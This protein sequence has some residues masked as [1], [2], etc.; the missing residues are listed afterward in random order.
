MP[1]AA[2]LDEYWSNILCERD[3]ITDVPE[4]RWNRDWY[5]DSDPATPDK[6]YAQ[7]GGFIPS[8]PFDPAQFGIPPASL[9]AIDT[10]QLMALALAAEALRDAGY[11]AG[12]E[13]DHSRTSV[14]L[15]VVGMT[16][17]NMRDLASRTE[18]PAW[19]WMMRQ[20]GVDGE[21]LRAVADTARTYYPAW[22]E[23]S[24]PGSLP[25]VV[26]GRIANRLDLGGLACSVDAACASSLCALSFAIGELQAGRCDLAV[27]GGVDMDN[28]PTS[29]LCF[30]K[31]HALSRSQRVRP[32]AD[33]ADGTLLA[34]GAGLL[35]LKRQEDAVRDGD[36]IYALI[37]GIG[38]TSD[39]RHRSIYAPRPEGQ[40]R[41]LEQAY[42]AADVDPA[43]IGLIEAHATG[44]EVGDIVEC[45]A[46]DAFFGQA[47]AR[48]GSVALGSVK[49]QI[50]HAKA[51]AGAA[52]L[53]KAA[54]AL[55]HRVLPATLHAGRPGA[56]L[57]RDGSPLSVNTATRPWFAPRD[58][59]PRRAGVSAFGFGGA[60]YHAVLE[61]APAHAPAASVE[62][63]WRQAGIVIAAATPE[64]LA[65]SC[66]RLGAELAGA[67][68]AEVFARLAAADA[69]PADWARIGF[70]AGNPA[71]VAERLAA[72]ETVLL[73]R[74]TDE[75][76]SLPAG[77][78]YRRRAVGGPDGLV[79]LFPGQGSQFVGMGCRLAALTDEVRSI[80]EAFDRRLT[81]GGHDP[82]SAVM[83]PPGAAPAAAADA[84]LR[85]TLYAQA[86]IGAL[87]VGL[88]RLL[89][90]AGVEPDFAGGHSFGE[91][92][93]LWAAG[94]MDE[95]TY[96][97]LVI[98]RGEALTPPADC[99]DAGTLLAVQA[100]EEQLRPLLAELPGVSLAN[101]NAPHQQVLGGSRDAVLRAETRLQAEGL[102][103]IPL[104][105]AAAFHTPLVSYAKPRWHGAL[106][107][108]R[109]SS[110]RIPVAANGAGGTHGD[111]PAAIA[112]ALA[113]HPFQ[114]VLFR[115]N[116]ETLYD[117]GGRIFLEIGPR[118]VLSRLAGTIL[119]DRPHAAIA[120]NHSSSA[121]AAVQLQEALVQLRVAG[122]PLPA[123]AVRNAPVP[124]SPTTI[125]LGAPAIGRAKRTAVLTRTPAVMPSE[126]TMPRPIPSA[127]HQ[128]AA[129]PAPVTTAPVTTAPVTPAPI[130][131][132]SAATLVGE[133]FALERAMLDAH[134]R[135]LDLQSVGVRL[136]GALASGDAAQAGID[137]NTV[138]DSFD[139]HHRDTV[140]LHE[141][142][143]KRSDEAFRTLVTGQVPSTAG[144]G[145]AVP[146]APAAPVPAVVA[147]PVIR[148]PV[149]PN[150][151]PVAAASVPVPAAAFDALDALTGIVAERTQY[152]REF[153]DPDLDLEADLGIDSIKRVEILSNLRQAVSGHHGPD[154]LSPAVVQAMARARS[155]RAIA[156]LVPAPSTPAP[157]PPAAPAAPAIAAPSAT[158]SLDVDTVLK[159]LVGIVADRTGYPE[160]ILDPALD[161][162]ADLGIDSI[163]RMDILSALRTMA[164]GHGAVV[165]APSRFI[166]ARTLGEIARLVLE[167][168]EKAAV[169]TPVAAPA[170]DEAFEPRVPTLIPLPPVVPAADP[171][172]GGVVV[173]GDDTGLAPALVR[174]LSAAGRGAVLAPILDDPARLAETL[175]EAARR[176][177]GAETL[178]AVLPA[179]PGRG[180]AGLEAVGQR[181]RLRAVLL[182]A[183]QA[184]AL[185][186]GRPAFLTVGRQDGA[187]GHG[188]RA[189]P[190]EP[191]GL[192]GLART[193][194]LEHP[195]VFAR[196]LDID[197][198]LPE[199]EA[200]TAVLA[201][202][203]DASTDD[204][205]V[206][207][208][209][210][211]RW[212]LSAVPAVPA[213]AAGHAPG[214][215]DLFLVTGGGRGITA[216]CV[217][218]L[219]RATGCRF[220][221]AGRTSI[222]G[223][224]PEWARGAAEGDLRRLCA[225][226]LPPGP[227]G[228]RPPIA[229]IE[230]AVQ[231]VLRRRSVLGT[232]DDLARQGIRARYVT[233][234]VSAPDA[235]RVALAGA[236]C[237]QVTGLIHGA[238][239][240]ADRSLDRK[241]AQDFDTVFAPKV[242]GLA[243]VLDALDPA[244]LRHIV[245]FS[246]TA[247]QYGN[248]GQ[249]DY[250]MA[251]CVL[252]GAAACL[253]HSLPQARVTA[254]AWGPWQGGMVDPGLLRHF[255][256][257]GVRSLPL[258]TGAALFAR[259][260]CGA[261]EN[262]SAVL[263]VGD[264][265]DPGG[266]A[267]APAAETGR[268]AETA[269]AEV[270][271]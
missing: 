211:G 262:R 43:T 13:R 105:V 189:V 70:V 1:Q 180:P 119:G 182:A 149:I 36:R 142:F 90:Q 97:D 32:F 131:P 17:A 113:E 143:L 220:V 162:E 224:E 235:L 89:R 249:A 3:C 94:V 251:N 242:D 166:G 187:F 259:A 196:A 7:R 64:E 99:A 106:R 179:L 62:P 79:A 258:D 137:P 98:A 96:I 255:A 20:Q 164:E 175:A 181:A 40:A 29:Y 122:L 45:E 205:V 202:L 44:T 203:A 237:G 112:A 42:R 239:A 69:P 156:A 199:D 171:R 120:V 123:T 124:T 213:T 38:A 58:G 18:I 157:Q 254:I 163:K 169:P 87:G 115:R 128:P 26:A 190:A 12:R 245:L 217:A 236:G 140:A 48:P 225:A 135:F 172:R 63:A 168:G 59:E 9:E 197:E 210:R 16:L 60:N 34:E 253:R 178:I 207:I 5:F 184:G 200:A 252:D 257:R 201:E 133:G 228:R 37:R 265:P 263:V 57:G 246:S 134:A 74:R 243:R 28:S 268:M 4:S 92:T 19:E 215:E 132:A 165:P 6:I 267:D 107:D 194:R 229:A 269:L 193:L 174:A 71:E 247:G 170:G 230:A 146:A 65:G 126:P 173:L 238:G 227:D 185:L 261:F 84:A 144:F 49:S 232:L 198:A 52:S 151:A 195:G 188:G 91:L 244:A 111:D 148:H 204:A 150:P 114:P 270:G 50:G 41:V 167:G 15:G 186:S 214:A 222:D 158:G 250:A 108:V 240:L 21:R 139:R 233:A 110:P 208:D 223:D 159:S 2:S 141:A 83:M 104:S 11:P 78:F 264:G 53:I 8:I 209:H 109:L 153:L 77:V 72:A 100:D 23:D 125:R 256:A 24:F 95:D 67:E 76:W 68:A 234:D 102:T 160:E 136:L 216:A 73:R 33:G 183:G 161:L 14:I 10:T 30:A 191:A 46:L 55:H 176:A 138:A 22:S 248:T 231:G 155:L 80:I 177:G 61:E 154:A 118:P 93:A 31:T 117:R 127:P 266:T 226:A 147:N 129:H 27:T 54:L 88:F 271:R 241:T 39:G 56:Y 152:P 192:A 82:L 81:A 86:G 75:A 212:G 47:G 121:D 101:A 206:G 116:I 260:V 25:N 218:A 66:A 85:R 219:G 103:A 145:A 130:V 51:A 35:V 221:L